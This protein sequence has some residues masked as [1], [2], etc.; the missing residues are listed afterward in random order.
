MPGAQGDIALDGAE[1][2]DC[3]GRWITPGLVDCHTH[4]VHGGD[5]AHE[6]ELRL[7]GASYQE[8]AAAGGGIVSTVEATRGESEAGLV[9]SASPRLDRLLA[10]GVTT[11]EVKS[12]YGLDLETELRM[13]R[14]ARALAGLRPVRIVTT[15]LG[16]HA[17][18]P[19]M[20]AGGLCRP[21]LQGDDP[22]GRRAQASPTRSTP[23]AKASPSRSTRRRGSS[24]PRDG[25]GCRS[26]SMPSSC[27]TAAERNS[28]RRSARCRRTTSSMPTRRT[29]PRW[30]RQAL[31]RCFCRGRSTC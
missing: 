18:P 30:A 8:I 23:S 29:P 15:F 28:P 1:R 20:C 4:L 21:R 22:G 27:R 10:E 13:L 2:I 26:A 19:E 6:F 12:G 11:V 9:A 24:R 16:A 31:W 7:A 25:P 14:A 3:G 5:R 17:F